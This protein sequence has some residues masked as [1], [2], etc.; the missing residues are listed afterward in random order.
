MAVLTA[1]VIFG[2]IKSIAKVCEA[3]VPFMAIFYVVGC[4]ILLIMNVS[5]IPATL[6]L[7]FQDAFTG[8]AM[9]GGFA[10]ATMKEAIRY[11]VAR[12]LFSQMN[13]AS[14]AHQLLPPPRKPKTPCARRSFLPPEHSGTRLLSAR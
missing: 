7:I 13:P 14:A 1:F 2:G 12:G 4:L 3:L 6:Q 8:Q 5:G 10:G 9:I 11:G